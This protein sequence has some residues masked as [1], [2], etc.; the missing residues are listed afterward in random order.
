[1]KTILAHPG[2]G[3]LLALHRADS[4]ASGRTTEHVEFCERV[5]RELPRS[6]LDP[7]PL[8]TGDDLVALGL[9]PGPVFKEVLASVREA[10]LEGTARTKE[11]AMTLVRRVLAE[12]TDIPPGG[13]PS[14]PEA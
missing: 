5:L 12:G 1:L 8:I 11:E 7:E 13:D 10:Q 14:E 3:E 4:I 9:P 2:I 6:E